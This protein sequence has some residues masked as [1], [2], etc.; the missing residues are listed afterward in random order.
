MSGSNAASGSAAAGTIAS[1]PTTGGAPRATAMAA[2]MFGVPLG[3]LA[4]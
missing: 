1:T 4:L 3:A 2:G